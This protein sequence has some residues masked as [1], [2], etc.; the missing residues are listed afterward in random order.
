MLKGSLAALEGLTVSQSVEQVAAILITFLMDSSASRSGPRQAEELLFSWLYGGKTKTKKG[1]S[2]LVK[3]ANYK[4][5]L[6]PDL[7][8]GRLMIL[9]RAL[10]QSS[11][12][13]QSTKQEIEKHLL[14]NLETIVLNDKAPTLQASRSLIYFQAF[15]EGASK[16][17]IEEKV[18]PRMQFI[19]NRSKGFVG[20]NAKLISFMKS[21]KIESEDTL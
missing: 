21:Y 18:L 2:G 17:T 19:T 9:G 6:R 15:L 8:L 12:L 5:F 13:G 14:D 16:E 20:I 11:D 7:P 10:T 4:L 3:Q 1:S